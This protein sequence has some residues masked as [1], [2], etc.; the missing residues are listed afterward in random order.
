MGRLR[1]AR[2]IDVCPTPY[3]Y[4]VFVGTCSKIFT[5]CMDKPRGAAVLN[6][7]KSRDSGRSLTHEFILNLVDAFDCRVGRVVIYHASNGVFLTKIQI[8]MDNELGKKIVE[9]DGRPSDTIPL[10]LLSGAPIFVSDS[11]V[12]GVADMSDVYKKMKEE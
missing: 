9:V 8:E 2:I 5:V 1:Q 6:A 10:S 3:G 4:A 12:D 11:V 7:F